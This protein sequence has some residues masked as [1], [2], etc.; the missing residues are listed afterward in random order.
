V[1]VEREVAFV[2]TAGG[3]TAE[4]VVVSAVDIDDVLA[5]VLTGETARDELSE[6]VEYVEAAAVPVAILWLALAVVDST[7][8]FV[9]ARDTKICVFVADPGRMLSD[10]PLPPGAQYVPA[11]TN[12]SIS[13]PLL[14]IV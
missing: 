3:V 10:P 13:C 11:A 7:A 5:S 8:D 6:A 9:S 2:V 14:Q 1:T 12:C 4:V